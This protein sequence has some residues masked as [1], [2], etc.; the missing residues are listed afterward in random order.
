MNA[1][2]AAVIAGCSAGA[3]PGPAV[4]HAAR[5]AAD[6]S[7]RAL[8]APPRPLPLPLDAYALTD[9]QA[10]EVS[11][12]SQLF[13]KSCMAGQKFD[14]PAGLTVADV[15]LGARISAEFTSRLWGVSDLSAA[16]E[17]GYHLPPWTS[18]TGVPEPPGK[19]PVAEQRAYATCRTS[20]IDQVAAEIPGPPAQLVGTLESESWFDA[21]ASARM[22]AVFARWSACMRSRGYHYSDPLQAAEAAKLANPVTEV[23]LPVTPAEV[24]T[25]VA[26]IGCKHVTGLL[27]IANVVQSAIQDRMIRQHAA[28][29]AIIKAQVQAQA[30]ALAR[31]A[32]RYG[33][34]AA[35]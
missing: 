22:R 14:F 7:V 21:K 29:M 20:V 1:L 12:L 6:S 5:S 18:G 2:L 31:L 23:P 19:M 4:R 16:R 24:R 35:S 33:I 17:Y 11:Y 30:Q 3:R 10:S 26:D 13:L 15:T 27:T 34:P 8:A 9:A 28:Q 32:A 25:A